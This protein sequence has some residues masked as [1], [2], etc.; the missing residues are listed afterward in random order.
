MNTRSFRGTSVVRFG[1]FELDVRAAELRKGQEKVRLQEQ[2]FRIL[3]MLLER[4]GEVV[5]REEICKR[6]WPN[7]TV[8]EVS[9]GINAA[10]LRLRDALGDSAEAPVYVETVARRGYRFLAPVQVEGRRPA[11]VPRAMPSADSTGELP[12]GQAIS[13]FRVEQKLG[14]GG[15]GVVYRAEDVNLSRPVAL[16]FLAP[17]LAGDPMAV[18]RFQREARTA[19][20][21]NHP[22]ICTVYAV[23]E[24]GGQ[25]VIVMEL[26][27]GRTLESLLADGPLPL[28]RALPLGVQMAA[29]LEAAHR[30]GIVHRDLKPGN[31]MVTQFG[32]KVLDFGLAKQSVS[33]A[34]TASGG[35][36]HAG[37]IVGTPNY[38]APE[39]F[40]GK[41]ADARSDI[42]SFGLVLFEMLAGARADS[43]RRLPADAADLEPLVR[44]AVEL[45]PE[46]RW[47][48]AGDLKAAL[49]CV[50]AVR[51]TR[52]PG[53]Q[54]A[55]VDRVETAAAIKIP[56]PLARPVRYAIAA[57]LIVTVVVAAAYEIRPLLR[58]EWPKLT[59]TNRSP[60]YT[61]PPAP[62]R[63]APAVTPPPRTIALA[64]LK[65]LVAFR[66]PATR[67]QV[68]G[69]FN[70]SP[71]GKMLAYASSGEIYV[72]TLDGSDTRLVASNP[73]MAG[74]PFWSPDG[75]SLAYT[76]GG[77]LYVVPATGGSAKPIGDVNTNIAGAWGPDGTIL[78]GEVREG[79]LA[80]PSSGGEARKITKPEMDRGETRHMSP[81]FLP[82]GRKY[83]YTAGSD[84]VGGSMLYAGSLDSSQRIPIVP[85]ESG[86][87]FVAQRGSKGVL[88]FVRR[89]D[90]M[91][92][93][94]DITTLRTEGEATKLA[95]PVFFTH[96]AAASATSIGE[97]SATPTTLVYH[98]LQN[99]R[100]LMSL[101]S[102]S[103]MR[104]LQSL[105]TPGGVMALENW[106][107]TRR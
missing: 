20:A 4:P 31:V 68:A 3:T 29:A 39:Q 73:G 9:H 25:P 70:L 87:N 13:H 21:L 16:K 83:L 18:S 14:S 93:A 50:A 106:I 97:F 49:E 42:Y 65:E 12:A 5:L 37:S 88:V 57:A 60:V 22:N 85:V 107:P 1:T 6:L 24:C 81:Q 84:K 72:R 76:N 69:R 7:G 100:P 53:P 95:G 11:P 32:L 86:V 96:A 64:T 90:L 98:S 30:K 94:F 92:Q 78:I 47:Q 23:E 67:P 63:A 75:K 41:E 28:E 45:R 38:M 36:T 82:G 8:V 62:L 48:N 59:A 91:A 33:G 99:A 104:A 103:P 74:T 27:E 51:F 56:R 43:G 71:D 15:M 101:A 2:P 58:A 66:L 10:V 17:D 105:S 102:A 44:R 19:S 54:S 52:T 40:Q 77:H 26:L 61:I 80:I 79:L 55:E 46:D 89:S 34:M 35:L